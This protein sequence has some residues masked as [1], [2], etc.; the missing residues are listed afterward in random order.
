MKKIKILTI[1][2][3]IVLI[4]MIAF[5]GIY[6][7][8][9]NRME[10]K[11]K[12]YSYAMD[13]KGTR[14]I[15]FKVN[16]ETKTV[17]KDK[18]GKEVE[19]SEDLTEEQIEQN[20][21]TKEETQYNNEEVLTEEN[22]KKCK[23]ILEKRLKKL[24]VDYYNVKINEQTG[25]IIIEI[26]ETDD[27]DSIVSNIGT[28]GKFEI[29][30]S[31][32]NEVLMDNND[33]KLANVLY[34]AGSTSGTTSSGTAVY[35]NIEFTKDGA[36]KLEDISSKYVKIEENNE[37]TSEES[38]TTENTESQENNE[39]ENKVTMKIDDEE[40]MSSSFDETLKT[41][42]L[43][44][45]V[46]SSSTDEKTLQGYTDQAKSMAVVLD[47]G[48]MPIKY[49]IDENKYVLSDITQNEINIVQYVAIGIAVISLVVL[50][51]RYKLN[52]LLGAISYIGLASLDL[53]LIRYANVLISIESILAIIITLILNYIFINKLLSKLKKNE[54][55]NIKSDIKETYKEFFIKII[56]ICIAVITFCFMKWTPIS[57]FGMTMFWG[58][59]L[60]AIYNFIITNN[61]LKIETSK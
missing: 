14:N 35:L 39:N 42:K 6:V 60:I 52:G 26:P 57:S 31:N 30:D 51:I 40:I 7:Q 11:V 25:D 43:Q 44:L 33:I 4:T 45:S 61:L 58:I 20:G 13:L 48:K 10:D 21:Y 38:N 24:G 53:L 59:V 18:D 12:D 9:Q 27:T 29:V 16:K 19:N 2:L 23:E 5:F 1:V 15:R 36:K 41:G 56:P 3:V 55:T 46:G 49:E 34:G 28:T 47:T 8:N 32:T 54:V 37:Q 17:I 50:I 22:Y